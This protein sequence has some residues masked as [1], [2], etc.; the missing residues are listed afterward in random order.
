MKLKELKGRMKAAFTAFNNYDILNKS[1]EEI[2]DASFT[3]LSKIFT[4][5]FTSAESS[6][7]CESTYFTCMKV[8]GESMGKLPMKV[9]QKTAE[10]GV[11]N[12]YNHRYYQMLNLRPN[13]NMTATTFFTMLENCRNHF[14]NGYAYIDDTNPRRTQLI[15]INPSNVQIYVDNAGLLDG[16]VFYEV[17]TNAGNIIVIPQEDVIHVKS[18]LTFNGLVGKSV[19]EQLL[20]TLRGNVKAQKMLND[21]YDSGMTAKAVLHYTG[22]INE[23]YRERL[24]QGIEEFKNRR[25]KSGGISNILPLPIGTDL[26]PLNLKLADS[27]F[28]ELSQF[29]ALKIASAFGVKPFQIGDYTKSSYSNTEAQQIAFLIDTLSVNVKQYEEEF[30]YKLIPEDEQSQGIKIAFN[31]L[32][33][34]RVDQK[35]QSEILQAGVNSG[36]YTP[37]EAR[38][39]TGLPAKPGGDQLM[40][41]GS[42]IPLTKLGYQYKSIADEERG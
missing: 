9:Q 32:A 36:R 40:C 21:M 42:N 37:N 17:T 30:T 18:H 31:T 1:L 4:R 28:L 26:V 23:Q 12:L 16:N 35:T 25:L 11:K 41:N 7:L 38:A 27:Q 19:R 8:L 33:L 13:Q 6:V 15:P 5:I 10:Y 29:S 3:D 39:L 34:L 20:E 22:D 14:G 24:V 2:N